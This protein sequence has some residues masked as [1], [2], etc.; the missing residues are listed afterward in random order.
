MALPMV[1]ALLVLVGVVLPAV[2]ERSASVQLADRV[3][4]R[5]VA[6]TEAVQSGI[7]TA[8]EQVAS[9]GSLCADG[10]P[11]PLRTGTN[12]PVTVTLT[13]TGT[14]DR[15]GLGPGGWA[16]FIAPGSGTRGIA[17]GR[18]GD[19]ARTI[20]GPTYDAGGW[21]LLDPL[22]ISGGEL[23]DGRCR[24][25]GEIPSL[26]GPPDL[27]RSCRT[28]SVP[29][30]P[31]MSPVSGDAPTPQT[32]GNGTDA[33]TA[34]GPGTYDAPPATVGKVR[35]AYFRSGVYVLDDVGTWVID[36]DIVAGRPLPGE[37]RRT[38]IDPSTWDPRC[39][40]DSAD[41]GVVF[42]LAGNSRIVIGTDARL[43]AAGW[44]DGSGSAPVSVR[45][46][47]RGDGSG[48]SP[49]TVTVDGSD[50]IFDVDSNGNQEYALHGAVWAPDSRVSVQALGS[51]ASARFLGG[52]VAGRLDIGQVSTSVRPGSFSITSR[53]ARTRQVRIV[54][55]SDQTGLVPI[56]AV[57]VVD[58]TGDDAATGARP[59]LDVRSWHVGR[60]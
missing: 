59:V 11:H 18:T 42:V 23:V 44:T 45:A 17:T 51:K 3:S 1:L 25:T 19:F 20:T 39:T 26:V 57:A 33:C 38:S 15:S 49:S 22:T 8:L 10:V 5:L 55:R 6:R 9:G 37:G 52:V 30:L 50:A 29:Q 58:I 35:V 16:V 56:E 13:C 24:D 7:R 14:T 31:P 36:R 40:A 21:D 47:V 12:A 43:E 4:E 27:V 41:N 54:A 60:V 32:F 28:A 46:V 53:A 48:L 2:L 34:F